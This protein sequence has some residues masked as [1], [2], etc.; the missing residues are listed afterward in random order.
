MVDMVQF[1]FSALNTPT[2]AIGVQADH[3]IWQAD[4]M[5]CWALVLGMSLRILMAYVLRAS[6][7]TVRVSHV[8][9]RVALK[10]WGSSQHF[11]PEHRVFAG[12]RRVEDIVCLID[13]HLDLGI[14]DI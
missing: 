12:L 3:M 9:T 6:G 4:H 2:S 7:F 11:R 13:N 8:Q 5:K 1:A 14:F 10:A